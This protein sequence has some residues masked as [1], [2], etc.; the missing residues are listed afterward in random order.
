MICSVAK[1]YFLLWSIRGTTRNA[2]EK[3]FATLSSLTAELPTA[4]APS[5]QAPAVLPVT[6]PNAQPVNPLPTVPQRVRVS[7]GVTTGLLI[8][9]VPP[10]YPIEAR[11]AHIQGTVTMQAEIN[12]TGDV[13]DIEALDGPLELVVSAVNAV[14]QW[15]YRPYLLLGEPVMVETQIQVNYQ[16]Q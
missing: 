12:R 1:D 14:R 10:I 15:K 8:K 7:S 4:N 5:S 2:V 6:K 16:L 13:M 3:A 11:Y 9:K